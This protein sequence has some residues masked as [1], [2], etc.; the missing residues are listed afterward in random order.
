MVAAFAM[1]SLQNAAVW[2][3]SLAL[4]LSENGCYW[5]ERE[6]DLTGNVIQVESQSDLVRK[7]FCFEWMWPYLHPICN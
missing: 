3:F 7:V 6:G 4:G 5:A 2:Y 1:S